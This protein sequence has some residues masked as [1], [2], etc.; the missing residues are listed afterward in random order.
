M[1]EGNG[2]GRIHILGHEMSQKQAEKLGRQNVTRDEA[3]QIAQQ[4]AVKVTEHLASQIP[5]LVSSVVE[6]ALKA[7][8]ESAGASLNE[9]LKAL[10]GQADGA[11]D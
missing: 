10:E 4:V 1:S 3:V 9:R 5:G 7:Y 11:S 2:T 8:H 6:A